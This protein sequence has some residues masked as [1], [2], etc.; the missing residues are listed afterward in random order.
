MHVVEVRA[1]LRR[2]LQVID[3]VNL[4]AD[5]LVNVGVVL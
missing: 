4:P 3:L 5:K 1:S 2:L